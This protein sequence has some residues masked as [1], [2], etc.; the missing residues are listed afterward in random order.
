MA[1]KDDGKVQET[2]QERALAEVASQRIADY[3]QRWAPLITRV[4]EMTRSMKAPDSFEREQMRGKVAGATR[5]A[6]SDATSKA[7]TAERNAGIRSSSARSKLNTVEQG[8]EE[9]TSVGIGLTKADQAID[10]AY[11][12]GLSQIMALGRGQAAGAVSNLGKSATMAGQ[13]AGFDAQMSARK[14]AGNAQLAGQV[15]GIGIGYGMDAWQR[16]SAGAQPQGA[17]NIETNGNWAQD[18]WR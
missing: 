2:E 8:A 17:F 10:D 14:R 9:A 4:G 18:D 5:V 6:F 1:G 3:K 11:T 16:P 15:A 13:Q 7:E 12:Q